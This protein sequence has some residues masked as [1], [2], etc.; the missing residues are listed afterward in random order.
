LGSLQG[1]MAG[2]AQGK[3][4]REVFFAQP[5]STARFGNHGD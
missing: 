5:L 2:D 3:G 1:V 4:L